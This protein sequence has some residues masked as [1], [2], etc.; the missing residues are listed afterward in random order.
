V[1]SESPQNSKAAIDETS[2]QEAII[3]SEKPA[4]PYITPISFE[5]A[6]GA[7]ESTISRNKDLLVAVNS[8][9]T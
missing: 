4:T 1:Q 5:R 3:S 9:A 7:Y 6:G 8:E 2:L